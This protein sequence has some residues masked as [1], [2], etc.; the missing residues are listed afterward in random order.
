MEE[1]CPCVALGELCKAEF[2][3]VQSERKLIPTPRFNRY[4]LLLSQNVTPRG[5][6]PLYLRH[7]SALIDGAAYLTTSIR[8]MSC[9]GMKLLIG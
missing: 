7:I 1:D 6:P 8:Y 5:N 2:R 4:L 9:V 3:Y